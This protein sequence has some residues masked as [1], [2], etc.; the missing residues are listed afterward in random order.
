MSFIIEEDITQDSTVYEAL[1]NNY[2]PGW[3]EQFLKYKNEIKEISKIVDKIETRDG[4]FEPP[5]RSLFSMFSD[6]PLNEVK[7]V[8]WTDEPDVIS[9][10]NVNIRKELSNE[11][12]II[13][14]QNFK[15]FSKQGVLFM[16]GSMSYSPR[17]KNLY[18]DVWLGFANIVINI[19]NENVPNCI[20]LIWGSN[21]TKLES[22][23]TSREVYT[24]SSPLKPYF[25]FNGCNH[26][27]KVNITLDRQKKEPINWSIPQ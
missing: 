4:F 14:R 3:T 7:V 13:P 27:I 11:L 1:F 20:H 17:D 21:C 9:K 26:F 22:Q 16:S 23:I 12:K 18:K 2:Y 19:I 24:T 10:A 5:K 6:T 8:V 15:D 25:G